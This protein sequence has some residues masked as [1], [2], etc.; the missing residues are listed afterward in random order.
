MAIVYNSEITKNADGSVSVMTYALKPEKS[1]GVRKDI[2]VDDAENKTD[3][4]L[5]VMAYNLCKEQITN[6]MNGV[7]SLQPIL[8]GN[9]VP[10]T[11]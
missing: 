11:E 4:E 3:E 9:F 6:Y 5:Q 2:T 1:I 7:Q 8:E 10:P